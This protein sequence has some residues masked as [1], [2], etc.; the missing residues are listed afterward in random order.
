[1]CW[2]LRCGLVHFFFLLGQT[3]IVGKMRR[4]KAWLPLALFLGHIQRNLPVGTSFVEPIVGATDV[5]ENGFA[6]LA[7]AQTI[8][9]SVRSTDVSAGVNSRGAIHVP[10][11]WHVEQREQPLVMALPAGSRSVLGDLC[12]VWPVGLGPQGNVMIF[13]KLVV[14]V[15][16]VVR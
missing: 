8:V 10:V 3:R 7:V 14:L 6:L 16:D 1:M 11:Q 4:A 12:S 13:A 9:I 2:V 5:R 15:E